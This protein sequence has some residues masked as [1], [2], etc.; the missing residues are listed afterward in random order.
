MT[1]NMM[2]PFFAPPRRMGEEGGGG[3]NLDSLSLAG[4]SWPSRGAAQVK[5]ERRNQRAETSM[6]KRGT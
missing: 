4:T 5:V 3:D 6:W 1:R 2:G